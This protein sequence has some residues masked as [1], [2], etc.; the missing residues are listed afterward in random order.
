MSDYCLKK[1]DLVNKEV[2]AFKKAY[3]A[4][5]LELIKIISSCTDGYMLEKGFS[6]KIRNLFRIILE[7]DCD[8]IKINSKD[9]KRADV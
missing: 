8:K 6:L 7:D 2:E 5:Y 1:L 3:P 9:Y 4:F